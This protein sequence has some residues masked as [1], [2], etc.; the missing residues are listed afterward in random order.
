MLKPCPNSNNCVSSQDPIDKKH[1]VRPLRYDGTLEDAKDT[2]RQAIRAIP[3]ARTIVEQDGGWHVEFVSRFF[4][5]VDDMDLEFDP[6][7]SLIHVRSASRIGTYDWGV[8]RRRVETLRQEL[9]ARLGARLVVHAD[10]A[11]AVS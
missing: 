9:D 3:G 6:G 4:R 11:G 2:L 10:A 5:F 8:N 1:Y 7:K